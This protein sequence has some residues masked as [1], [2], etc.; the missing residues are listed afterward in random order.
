MEPLQLFKVLSD[1]TRLNILLLLKAT[2]ELCVCDIYT[3]LELSQP[4]TSRHLAMLREAG[5]L[6]DSKH[7]KWVHYRISPILSPWI[8]N[9]IDQV[10]EIEKKRVAQLLR[11][12]GKQG[13][14]DTF[15]I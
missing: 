8:K 15:P 10:Y 2:G 6:L 3:A 7:G 12:I 5:L 9:V 4:K 14:I 13:P 1:E 11:A